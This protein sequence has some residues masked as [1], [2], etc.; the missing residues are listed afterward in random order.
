MYLH[1]CTWLSRTT[2]YVNGLANQ[3]SVLKTVNQIMLSKNQGVEI[4]GWEVSEC[5]KTRV[6]AKHGVFCPLT[7]PF[8]FSCNLT[9]PFVQPFW[10]EIFIICNEYKHSSFVNSTIYYYWTNGSEQSSFL[11]TWC[12]VNILLLVLIK[13]LFIICNEWKHSLFVMNKYIHYL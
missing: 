7:C 3:N 8:V 12:I 10:S 6:P 1:V 5:G 11:T 2:F 13:K 9:C 4:P